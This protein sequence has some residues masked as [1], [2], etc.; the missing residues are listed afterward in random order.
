MACS[1]WLTRRSTRTSRGQR[2]APARGPPVNWYVRRNVEIMSGTRVARL[3]SLSCVVLFA[4][5]L[6]FRALL[7]RHI[8]I[9]PGDPYGL[10]DVIE[11][12]LG[13]LLIG[14]LVVSTVVLL[15]LTI[16]GPRH[17]RVAAAWLALVIGGVVVLAS[18]LHT[19]AAKWAF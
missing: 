2:F 3:L 18:P 15:V 14:L 16:R 5:G 7:Y 17:N 1:S 8:Y 4:V 10:A 11:F 13:W 12:G 6:L 9:A 19:L